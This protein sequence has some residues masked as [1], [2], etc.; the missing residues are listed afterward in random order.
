MI[1]LLDA[2]WVALT[3]PDGADAATAQKALGSGF[4]VSP[5]GYIVTNSHVITT[6]GDGSVAQ[7]ADD[8]LLEALDVLDDTA[9]R[10]ALR[11]AIAGHVVTVDANDRYT[12]RHVLLREVV[13]DDLLPGERSELHRAVARA[14]EARLPGDGGPGLASAIA[15]TIANGLSI[16]D[17]VKDAQEYTWQTLKAAFRPGMGQ[18]IPDRLFWAR[19]DEPADEP[20]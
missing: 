18:H 2:D 17:A 20:D 19:E 14:L 16:A 10:T 4:V 6:A 7:P 8:T 12:F 3:S 5:K 1:D 15:A 13:Y 9:L 11:D